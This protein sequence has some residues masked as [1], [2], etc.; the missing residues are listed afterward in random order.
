[1]RTD[2]ATARVLLV[3]MEAPTNLGRTTRSDSTQAYGEAARETNTPLLPFLLDGV[4]GVGAPESGRWHSPEHRR[5]QARRGHDVEVAAAADLRRD[6]R[7]DTVSH[8]PRRLAAVSSHG[9]V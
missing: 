1:M 4:A 9:L 2:A 6:S 7:D 5:L 3:Q 8:G